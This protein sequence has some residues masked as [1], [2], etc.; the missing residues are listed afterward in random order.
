VP[1]T[2][3]AID[4]AFAGSPLPTSIVGTADADVAASELERWCS[5]HLG[6]Q[7]ECFRCEL[8]V[9]IVFGVQLEDERRVAV[10]AHSR[11]LS[12]P[13][14]EEIQ[15]AQ[16]RLAE[17]GFPCPR[18]LAGPATFL[19]TLALAEEWLDGAPG[20]WSRRTVAASGKAFA[21][22]VALLRELAPKSA[23]PRTMAGGWPPKPHNALFD[24]TRDPAGAAWIDAIA[25]RARER[26]DVGEFVLGHSDWSAK[27]VRFAGDEV[28][29]T[30]DWDSLRRER[31]PVLSGCAAACHHVDLDPE[32][33]WRAEPERVRAYLDE[34]E[35]P[36]R[37]REAALAAAVYLF[38]YTARCEHGFGDV[39][40]VTRMRE[41]LRDAASD[42]L[43]PA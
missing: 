18:P 27:H 32:D 24:F 3:K 30:Y 37:E 35:L 41:T 40:T 2:V 17:A 15:L 16:H 12:R 31:M 19:A 20:D 38:A 6:L 22:H 9:G 25:L 28:C 13:Q 36:R 21:Q 14:L 1:G 39:P 5:A 26:L 33:P 34:L 42:L 4:R 11:S 43:G 7:G 8:S 10:K 29:A 23:L